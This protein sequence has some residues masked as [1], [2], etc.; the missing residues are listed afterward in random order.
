MLY[1]QQKRIA[2]V[3]QAENKNRKKGGRDR[4]RG[5]EKREVDN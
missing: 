2:T 5:G 1:E 3:W 4:R